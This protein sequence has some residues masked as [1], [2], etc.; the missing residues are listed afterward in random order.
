[1]SA[2]LLAAKLRI[3]PSRPDWMERGRLEQ[4]LDALLSPGYK[5]GLVCAPAGYGKTTLLSRWLKQKSLRVCWISLE[6][7]D[8][9]PGLFF[10][11]LSAGLGRAWPEQAALFQSIGQGAVL[12]PHAAI[13][14]ILALLEELSERLW[15]VLDD[16]H[17]ISALGVQELM[18]YFLEN[19]PEM[20]RLILL[21]RSDPPLALPRLRAR[22]QMLELRAQDLRFNQPEMAAFFQQVM[23]LDLPEP[24]LSVLEARTEGWPAG[25]QM[26]GISM[27]GLNTSRLRC[28]TFCLKQPCWND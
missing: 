25:L 18:A 19:L 22:N 9:D 7:G 2:P 11:N 12:D 8:N 5:L 21:T 14:G 26:A 13:A 10:A 3:P 4:R 6:P 16:Y 17:F 20:V 23:G 28:R 1:M 27:Q 24:D 15:I